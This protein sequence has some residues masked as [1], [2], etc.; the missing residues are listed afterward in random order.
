MNDKVSQSKI[1]HDGKQLIIKNN[2]TRL[3]KLP[4]KIEEII[5]FDDVIVVRV[6]PQNKEFINEN[7]F[8]VSYFGEILWQIKPIKHV[9]K[10]SPYTSIFKK[11]NSVKAHNWDGTDLIIKPFTGDIKKEEY[12][13]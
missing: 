9:F 13:K 12:S 2:E 5:E 7:I 1:D 8:G 11:G 6:Y 3:V 4:S 10:K